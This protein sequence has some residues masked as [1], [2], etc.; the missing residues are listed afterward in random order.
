MSKQVP[1]IRKVVLVGDGG[2]G[3][4]CLAISFHYGRFPERDMPTFWENYAVNMEIEGQI[5]G[6]VLCDTAGQEDY[7]RLRPLS[8]PN[9][10]VILI[11]FSLDYPESFENVEQKWVPEVA[12]FC[13]GVPFILVR[14]KKDLT[15]GQQVVDDI[16]RR[17][18]KRISIEYG[19]ALSR[20][21]GASAYLECSAK[22][23][24]GV[25]QVF[26]TAAMA[27]CSSDSKIKPRDC[28][29]V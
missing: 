15:D 11:C 27:T 10:D 28:V 5:I 16:T 23:G 4:T 8:Y 3:K 22:S 26:Q 25:K 14:C 9:T 7:D 6:L 2:V 12:H 20:R 13:P 17:G 1:N 24:E 18:E 29:I 21:I 19:E